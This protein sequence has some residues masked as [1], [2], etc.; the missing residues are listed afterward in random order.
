MKKIVMLIV[1]LAVIGGGGWY[2]WTTYFKG[3]PEEQGGAP[4][5]QPVSVLT[6]KKQ[7]IN[8]TQSLP[9]RISAFKQ[10]QIRPQVDGIITARLF[11]EG[12]DVEQG[13]QLYQIDD[14]P[15]KAALASTE[16]DL[17]SAQANVTSVRAKA[18]RY[19]ELVAV[20][21]VSRQEYDDAMAALDQANAAIAVANAAVDVA[22]VNLNYTKVYAPISGRIGK[23][24]FTEGS[25]VTANQQEPMAVITQLDPV[26]VDMTQPGAQAM[27]LRSQIA[28]QDNIPVQLVLDDMDAPYTHKGV[29]K[30]SDVT[31]DETTGSVALRAVFPNPDS[32]L[33]PGLFVQASV[34]LGA[35][36]VMLV[37]QRAAI[38]GADGTMSVWVV[39]AGN[40]AE[41]R[42]IVVAQAHEDQW[43]VTSGLN[44]GDTIIME[45][46]QK[47]GPGSVVSPSPWTKNSDAQQAAAGKPHN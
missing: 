39:S 22:K 41:P 27:K 12:G 3:E 44:E 5:A 7:T 31:V 33:L 28:S 38:R 14:A 19:K 34:S 1:V 10:S 21:A 32:L 37:P 17:K 30:F 2:I 46:Y 47:V 43:I 45:G 18:K 13:Q 24:I 15:Y 36:T 11:E 35:Q 9:G 40:K 6:V 26:Y 20:N 29:L 16:A 23:S 4:A 42:P 8:M 25:L